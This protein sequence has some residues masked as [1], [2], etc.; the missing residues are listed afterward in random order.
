MAKIN[1]MS[2]KMT[3]DVEVLGVNTYL[4]SNVVKHAIVLNNII[5]RLA[6]NDT[7]KNEDGKW[8]D[9]L[10]ENGNKIVR[11]YQTNEDDIREIAKA[12]EFLNTLMEAFTSEDDK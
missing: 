7:V 3:A 10:D 5:S 12:S 1:K 9:K 8:V 4:V 2:V 11:Y 6:Y